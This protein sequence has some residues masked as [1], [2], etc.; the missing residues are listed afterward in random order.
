MARF[1]GKQASLTANRAASWIHRARSKNLA[2]APQLSSK[3]ACGKRLTGSNTDTR[4]GLPAEDLDYSASA[5]E[6]LTVTYFR[7]C[8]VMR[9][10]CF[11]RRVITG[12]RATT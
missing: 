6:R 2:F 1:A 11:G 7:R 3:Q 5:P 8:N 10:P 9:I 12:R 4:L